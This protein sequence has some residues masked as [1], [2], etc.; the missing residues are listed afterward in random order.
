MTIPHDPTER[1]A[2]GQ[3]LMATGQSGGRIYGSEMGKKYRYRGSGDYSQLWQATHGLRHAAGDF[4]RAGHLGPWGTAAGNAARYFGIGDYDTSMGGG[5]VEN[6][7]VGE[8]LGS[9]GIPTFGPEQAEYRITK[10]EFLRQ[11][12]APAVAGAFQNLVLPLQPGLESTFPWLALVAPQFEEYE[13]LQLM[14]YWRPMVSDFNSGTG[15]VGEVVMA[16]QYNPGEAPFADISRAK[17]Y[18]GAMSTKSSI[19]MRH[20]VECDP[21]KNSGAAGKY[22]RVGPLQGPNQDIKQYDLG[23][24]NVMVSGTPPAYSNQVLGELWVAYTVVLRKPKLP[25]SGGDDILRDYFQSEVPTVDPGQPAPLTFDGMG[26]TLF[27]QQNR[28]NGSILWGITS[29]PPTASDLFLNYTVPPW[30]AGD[31][32]ITVTLIGVSGTA[33]SI[34]DQPAL[35]GNITNI[36]DMGNAN[37][38]SG[39]H[40]PPAPIA[41][42]TSDAGHPQSVGIG[43]N[44]IKICR[45]NVGESVGGAVNTVGLRVARFLTAGTIP[46]CCGWSVDVTEY[47]S[48]FNSATTNQILLVDVEGQPVQN[49]WTL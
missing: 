4:L 41:Y 14:F 17:N 33:V 35:Q 32:Q 49:P 37:G 1:V 7:L 34:Y 5:A 24:L 3:Y 9:A 36:P 13:F 39:I 30:F 16:T 26:G 15:Q 38:A 21:L 23:T 42:S 25:D 20:G 6:T 18:M 22:V 44:I 45:V 43:E 40:G 8:G 29:G 10:T 19:P 11:L 46:A 31:L 27:G 12:Y 48:S 2:L 47:N 28:F